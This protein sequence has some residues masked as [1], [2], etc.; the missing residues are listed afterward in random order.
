MFKDDYPLLGDA[1]LTT[2]L[3]H[4]A[5]GGDVTVAAG[6]ARVTALLGAAHEPAGLPADALGERIGRNIGEMTLAG[7]LAPA[8]PGAWAITDRGRAQLRRHPEGTDPSDF[9]RYPEYAAHVRQKARRTS[10][11]DPRAASYDEG[12]ESRREGQPFTANPYAPSTADCLSWENGWMQ[13][14][15]DEKPA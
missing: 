4:L 15:D 10:A 8:A 14:L 1:S 3:L 2:L 11:A 7:L 13:A 6:I 9:M 5:A 12:Y